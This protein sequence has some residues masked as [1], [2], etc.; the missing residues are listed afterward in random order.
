MMYHTVRMMTDIVRTRVS[1]V[2]VDVDDNDV[3]GRR[4]RTEKIARSIYVIWAVCNIF[5]V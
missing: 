5:I 2:D 3:D 1:A 4:G